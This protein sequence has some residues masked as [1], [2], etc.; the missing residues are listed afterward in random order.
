MFEQGFGVPMASIQC[1]FLSPSKVGEM[2]RL[3]LVDQPDRQKFAG[4]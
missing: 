2:L 4:T 1:R 3:S